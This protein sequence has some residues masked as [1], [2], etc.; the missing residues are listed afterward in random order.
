MKTL[1]LISVGLMAVLM[2]VNFTACDP[3]PDPEE[4]DYK[5][6]P[7]IESLSSK[8]FN[9]CWEL[10]RKEFY[11]NGKYSE[12]D[13]PSS[14]FVLCFSDEIFSDNRYTLK[15]K[16]SKFKDYWYVDENGL[17]YSAYNYNSCILKNEYD[18]MFNGGSCYG[19]IIKKLSYDEL[20]IEYNGDL[21]YFERSYYSFKDYDDDYYNG[22]ED[23]D[24][25]NDDYYDDEEDEEKWWECLYCK[26]E[27]LCH[28]C[29]GDGVIG[30]RNCTFCDGSGICDHC[31]GRGGNYE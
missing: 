8:L 19:G 5:V 22:T 30:N 4:P 18:F 3:D 9:T 26:G 28:A 17:T 15:I 2:C 27:G 7:E 10:D 13:R 31:D 25:S 12:T 20:V 16:G 29:S 14:S 11:Y 6:D 24:N 1:R 23:D 21:I